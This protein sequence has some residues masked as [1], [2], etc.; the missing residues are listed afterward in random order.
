MRE[1][2]ERTRSRHAGGTQLSSLAGTEPGVSASIG[3]DARRVEWGAVEVDAATTNAREV[4]R[5][6]ASAR[7]RR[8]SW[9]LWSFV[10]VTASVVAGKDMAAAT[11]ATA[12]TVRRS[13]CSCSNCHCLCISASKAAR[14]TER[15]R[16]TGAM[17]HS[18]ASS[19]LA[20]AKAKAAVEAEAEA[21]VEAEAEAGVEAEAEAGVEGFGGAF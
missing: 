3:A 14:C 13:W 16:R 8:L 15:S 19:A 20:I 2:L 18:K 1:R 4:L 9:R 12:A 7:L 11:R 10:S 6:R 5:R 21:A 17:G